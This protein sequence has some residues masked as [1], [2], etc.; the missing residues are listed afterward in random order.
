MLY[1]LTPDLES[2]LLISLLYLLDLDEEAYKKGHIED[3]DTDTA[4]VVV[5][6]LLPLLLF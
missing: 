1:Y 2:D 5:S 6:V 4:S 3:P